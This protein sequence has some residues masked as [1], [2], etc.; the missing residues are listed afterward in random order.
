MVA[1]AQ[2]SGVVASSLLDLSLFQGLSGAVL[3]L[4]EANMRYQVIGR[5]QLLYSER[6]QPDRVFIILC[7]Y[8][9]TG[10]LSAEGQTI[11]KAVLSSGDLLGRLAISRS[12]YAEFATGHYGATHLCSCS[13]LIWKEA[14]VQSPE[15]SQRYF[16][17]LTQRL[18]WAEQRA[19]H[20]VQ[21][22][23]KD[24]L[25]HFFAAMI[26]RFPEGIN[27]SHFVWD[28]IYSQSDIGA[29]IGCSRQTISALM[30]QLTR[31]GQLE[32][33]GRQLRIIQVNAFLE[34]D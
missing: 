6:Y 31:E 13:T 10:Y 3:D 23:A 28:S 12:G 25:R 29:L 26:R 11:Y 34:T 1:S 30:N 16:E 17:Y 9:K 8:L 5:N 18:Q 14:L 27:G 24:R 2:S 15:L 21:A 20:L 22:S 4:L 33:K 32:M 7:G 19:A